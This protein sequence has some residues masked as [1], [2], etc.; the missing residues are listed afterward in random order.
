[1]SGRG[2]RVIDAHVHIQPWEQLEPEVAKVMGRGRPDLPDIK[3]FIE[4]SDDFIEFLDAEG[5]ARVALINYPADDLMGFGPSVNDYCAAYRDAHP[6]RIIAFGGVHP[7]L[8]EDPEREVARALDELKLDGIKIHPP[9]QL[10][11]PN[12]HLNG[13][14]TLRLLYE[15]CQD[16]RVPVMIHTGTSIFPKARGKYGDPITVDDVAVDFPELPLIMAHGGRPI[17]ME[18]AFHLVRRHPSVYMDLS[19]IP[20][21][22]L[23]E[24]FPRL[25]SIASK[26]LFGTDWPSP[27]VKS[28][29]QNVDA[30][31]ELAISDAAKERIFA[32]TADE[33]FPPR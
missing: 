22:A 32:G 1:M 7:R 25:E 10:I 6:D 3:R 17:W 27:G 20:P 21:K 31:A 18:T 24:Y 30:I 33:L 2:F 26:C 9:H 14:E 29:R 12:D 5:L 15:G 28:I 23:L 13:N 19:G 16:R 4:N 11:F 8:S